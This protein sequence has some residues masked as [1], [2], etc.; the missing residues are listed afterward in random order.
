MELILYFRSNIQLKTTSQ[1]NRIDFM[2]GKLRQVLP[3]DCYCY[4]AVFLVRKLYLKYE[5][6]E[7]HYSRRHR[8]Y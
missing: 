5:N 7:L 2:Y 1:L 3:D 8:F 6:M 4:T